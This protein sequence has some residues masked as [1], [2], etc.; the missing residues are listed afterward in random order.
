MIR[1]ALANAGLTPAT[2]TRSRATAPVRCWA[3]RSRPRRCWPPTGRTAQ[4]SA[5][6]GSMKSNIGHTPAAAGVAG[7]IK[8]V[9]AMRHDVLPPTLH[10]DAPSPHVDW[11]SGQVWLLTEAVA[12]QAARPAAA[13]GG[14][15]VRDQRHQRARDLRGGTGRDAGNRPANPAR[16]QSPFCRPT[17]VPVLVSATREAALR[18]QAEPLRAHLMAHPEL[19]LLDVGFSSVTTRTQFKERARWWLGAGRAAGG[20]GGLASGGSGAAAVGR[21]LDRSAAF[22][23]TGQG[24]QRAGM[25]GELAAAFPRFAAALD[26]CARSLSPTW[27]RCGS[28]GV[29]GAELDGGVHPAGVVRGRGVAVRRSGAGGV[30]GRADRASAGRSRRRMWPGR[31]R[32]RCV[33][34]VVARGRLTGE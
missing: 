4:R 22:V 25:G 18:G 2:S 28:V 8:M 31:C 23:F 34:A 11:S 14:V 7:V 9:L 33:R 27:L 1:Q 12:W 20:A 32:C 10:A 13:G 30:A 17:A 16:G 29:G 24:A 5:G 19:A 3:T 6:L 21:V 26:R 15:L